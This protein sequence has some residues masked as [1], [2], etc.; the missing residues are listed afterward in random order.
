MRLEIGLNRKTWPDYYFR[1]LI[2]VREVWQK[3]LI[4]NIKLIANVTRQVRE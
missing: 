2:D 4:K 1:F 3:M